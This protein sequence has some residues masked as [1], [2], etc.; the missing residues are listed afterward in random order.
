MLKQASYKNSGRSIYCA[1]ALLGGRTGV[2]EHSA[3]KTPYFCLIL[4]RRI[5]QSSRSRAIVSLQQSVNH[6]PATVSRIIALS[7]TLDNTIRRS[8]QPVRDTYLMIDIFN[9]FSPSI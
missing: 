4:H 5:A 3:Q 7:V 2:F 1:P 9:N 8:N 6:D